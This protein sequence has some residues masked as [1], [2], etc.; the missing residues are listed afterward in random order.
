MWVALIPVNLDN[1]FFVLVCKLQPIAERHQPLEAHQ[2]ALFDNKQQANTVGTLCR[3]TVVYDI[4][5]PDAYNQNKAALH[6]SVGQRIILKGHGL[7]RH[8]VLS[9]MC[10]YEFGCQTINAW[11]S[12]S[13]LEVGGLPSNLEIRGSI[14]HRMC[15][16]W[17]HLDP[18]AMA[19]LNDHATQCCD[20]I[21]DSNMLL[22]NSGVKLPV[23]R[24]PHHIRDGQG[25]QIQQKSHI[26]W[27]MAT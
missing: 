17:R 1:E 24:L 16:A 3:L 6:L 27:Q 4:H 25:L 2:K 22:T 12:C 14:Q 10:S 8:V 20:T 19:L 23:C 13:A 26:Q 9:S 15:P 21:T 11:T 18:V 7:E 5:V